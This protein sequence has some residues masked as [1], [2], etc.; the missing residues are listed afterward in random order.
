M[1]I[2][3]TTFLSQM[4]LLGAFVLIENSFD[5]LWGAGGDGKQCLCPILFQNQ[6]LTARA[7]NNF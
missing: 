3:V 4:N 2:E 1:A 6:L 5:K 7:V